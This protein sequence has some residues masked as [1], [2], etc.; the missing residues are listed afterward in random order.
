MRIVPVFEF[1]QERVMTSQSQRLRCGCVKLDEG[2]VRPALG[3]REAV[4]GWQ[5]SIISNSCSSSGII[6][7]PRTF[8]METL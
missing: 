5:V 4:F 7:D 8:I 6:C 1:A 2:N 3:I